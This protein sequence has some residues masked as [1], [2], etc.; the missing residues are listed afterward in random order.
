MDNDQ[1]QVV[2]C[3]EDVAPFDPTFIEQPLI[4]IKSDP[5]QVVICHKDVAPFDS[6]FV[7][8]H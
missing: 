6:T 8:S 5:L 4:I 1:L 3:H 2:I 7:F